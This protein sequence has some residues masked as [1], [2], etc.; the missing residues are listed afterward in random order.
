PSILTDL[1]TAHFQRGDVENL[2]L[3]YGTAV[4]LLGRVLSKEPRDEVA[5]FNRAIASD[6]L[7]LYEQ[8]ISD[9]E[10]YLEVD[11]TGEWAAEA[12]RRLADVEK[13]KKS[14]LSQ[15]SPMVDPSDAISFLSSRERQSAGED[16]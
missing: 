5:L 13:R 6:R 3:E 9:W 14:A 2:P 15:P 7:F 8:E 12:K 11:P 10:H 1:A 16:A 4:E